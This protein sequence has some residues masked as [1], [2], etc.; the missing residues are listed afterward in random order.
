MKD[1]VLSDIVRLNDEAIK[2][3]T[4]LDFERTECLF[5]QTLTLLHTLCQSLA[6]HQP[7]QSAQ[8]SSPPTSIN[9]RAPTRT[10]SFTIDNSFT[11]KSN[12][13][14]PNLQPESSSR[15][16]AKAFLLWPLIN[17]SDHHRGSALHLIAAVVFYNTGLFYHM[18]GASRYCRL[19]KPHFCHQLVRRYYRQADVLLG[20]FMDTTRQ[21][22]RLLWTVQAA[23]W[24]NLSMNSVVVGTKT[25]AA[26]A[27]AA[28]HREIVWVNMSQLDAFVGWVEDAE[29]RTFFLQSIQLANAAMQQNSCRQT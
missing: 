12:V 24:H 26:A 29:D 2:H 5:A 11:T 4:V 27:N 8:T 15:P 7:G 18:G 14:I 3:W 25:S 23:I 17:G 1:M 28:Y 22:G 6:Q 21:Q 9:C 10:N 13:P 16:Y 20:R 19:M